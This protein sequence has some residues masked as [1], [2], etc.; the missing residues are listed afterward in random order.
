MLRALG[1]LTCFSPALNLMSE[2][3]EVIVK[4][5]YE[6]LRAIVLV[7]TRNR[8]ELCNRV[9]CRLSMNGHNLLSL[10]LSPYQTT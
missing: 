7:S 5:A 2:N 6:A 8:L 9:S 10:E 1:M 4:R 3:L